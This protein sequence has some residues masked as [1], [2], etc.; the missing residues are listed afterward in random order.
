MLYA[1]LLLAQ[2]AANQTGNP[3][4]GPPWYSMLVWLL[5]IAILFYLLLLKPAQTQ[6]KQRQAMIAGLQKN[7][8]VLVALGGSGGMYATVV[9]VHDTKDEVVVRLDDNTRVRVT[10][11]SIVQ[12]L[13]QAQRVK[14]AA[15]QAK[16]TK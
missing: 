5:P 16:A 13:T 1:I 4:G 14:D 11:G 2:D 12:N 6:E 9:S 10:K 8:E 15:A 3:Q 7:D